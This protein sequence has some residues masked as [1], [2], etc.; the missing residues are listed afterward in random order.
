MNLKVGTR[1]W[2]SDQRDVSQSRVLKT[3]SHSSCKEG[4]KMGFR[5]GAVALCRVF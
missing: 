5:T 4:I 2:G 3:D 1:V